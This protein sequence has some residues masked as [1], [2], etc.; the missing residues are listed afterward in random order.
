MIPCK[1]KKKKKNNSSKIN[2][3]KFDLKLISKM[4]VKKKR[5]QRLDLLGTSDQQRGPTLD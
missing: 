3:A 5:I 2:F 4:G 1:K